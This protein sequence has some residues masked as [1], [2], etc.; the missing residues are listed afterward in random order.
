MRI[1]IYD[2]K[3]EVLQI[4]CVIYTKWSNKKY[5]VVKT[6]N[7]DFPLALLDL[8]SNEIYDEFDSLSTIER[9]FNGVIIYQPNEVSMEV[10]K[11]D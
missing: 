7:E 6:I 8:D 9:E 1:C 10:G 4:G 5:L 3:Q 11:N 2:K